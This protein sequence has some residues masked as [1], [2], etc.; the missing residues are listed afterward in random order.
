MTPST[1]CANHPTSFSFIY[2]VVIVTLAVQID[3]DTSRRLL[4]V[5]MASWAISS[6]RRYHLS[7]LWDILGHSGS[8]FMRLFRRPDHLAGLELSLASPLR[9]ST[10]SFIHVL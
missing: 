10:S 7:C 6:H 2:N 5:H 8:R 1:R 9:S 4:L 3:L